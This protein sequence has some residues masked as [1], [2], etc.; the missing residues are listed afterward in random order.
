[1][2]YTFSGSVCGTVTENIQDPLTGGQLRLYWPDGSGGSL[3]SGH[4]ERTDGGQITTDETGNQQ[5]R[6]FRIL[7]SADV[8]EKSDRLLEEC[9]ILEGGSFSVALGETES[10]PDAGSDEDYQGGPI[11]IDVRLEYLPGQEPHEKDGPIQFTIA[12]VQ[13]GWQEAENEDGAVAIWHHCLTKKQ[14]CGIK[15][16]YGIWTVCGEVRDSWNQPVGNATVTAFDADIVQD[17]KIGSATTTPSGQYRIDYR[18]GDF[19]T[20][21]SPWPAVEL[22]HGPDLY[23]SVEKGGTVRLDEN[24]SEGRTS[25]R[26]DASHCEEVD[27]EIPSIIL[28]TPTLWTGIGDTFTVP[29]SP[30]DLNDVDAEGYLQPNNWALTGTPAMSGNISEREFMDR[31]DPANKDSTEYRFVVFKQTEANDKPT[32]SHLQNGSNGDPV[33]GGL[34]RETTIGE[35]QYFPGGGEVSIDVEIQDSHVGSKGWVNI[36]D[37]VDD[38]FSGSG[39]GPA[40]DLEDAL[41]NYGPVYYDDKDPLMRINTGAL[42]TASAPSSNPGSLHNPLPKNTTPVESFAIRFETRPSGTTSP[43]DGKTINSIVMDNTSTFREMELF[44]ADGDTVG[45][46]AQSGKMTVK[47]NAY[48]PHLRDVNMTIEPNDGSPDNIAGPDV[49]STPNEVIKGINTAK[50]TETAADSFEI[51]GKLTK[52]CAYSLKL[53]T[54]RRVH[55]GESGVGG[56]GHMEEVFFYRKSP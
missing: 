10:E 13:P 43:A 11:E 27:L 21:P 1:M 31:R 20:T 15:S 23:F 33:T 47:F 42:T 6:A 49:T 52:T 55:N 40:S 45:C 48:H 56:D 17:D 44:N 16:T 39:T 29:S 22:Q 19:E 37:V 36:R 50:S 18:V 14:W 28:V 34:F 24:R 53:W 30:G 9:P 3:T 4:R 2:T 38:A 12:R 51:T 26:E 25:G 41:R 5:A 32:P 8:T 46:E 54:S 35:I 7:E